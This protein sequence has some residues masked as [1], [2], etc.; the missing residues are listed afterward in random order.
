MVELLVPGRKKAF[1]WPTGPANCT[2][3]DNL[4]RR[5]LESL[6]V[7]SVA[8]KDRQRPSVKTAAKT[9]SGKE[10]QRETTSPQG[11]LGD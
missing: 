9:A 5:A 8:M 7:T 4:P 6:R 3:G 10:S 1:R 2:R 11:E